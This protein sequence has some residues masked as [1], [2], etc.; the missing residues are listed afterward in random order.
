MENENIIRG[1]DP[2]LRYRLKKAGYRVAICPDSWGYHPVPDKFPK[3]IRMFF[4]SGMGSA[5]VQRHYPEY[6]IHDS[7]DHT[8][9]F[10]EKT[11]LPFRLRYSCVR[12]LQSVM[13]GHFIYAA[14]RVSYAMDIYTACGL[15]SP[16]IRGLT[17]NKCHA[18]WHL[19]AVCRDG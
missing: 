12:F 1:T 4:Y 10:R 19:E 16:V 8:A 11:T 14:V 7:E 5:W 17:E 9:V 3:L 6:A 2:D 13:Q 15:E 18:K